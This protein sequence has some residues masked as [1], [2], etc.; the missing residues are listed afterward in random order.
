MEKAVQRTLGW[1]RRGGLGPAQL[2]SWQAD[3]HAYLCAWQVK[4]LA[5][6]SLKNPVRIFVNSNT[7]VAPFLRQEFIRIRPNREGDREAIVA[8]GRKPRAGLGRVGCSSPLASWGPHR[9]SWVSPWCL[10]RLISLSPCVLLPF[11]QLHHFHRV[12]SPFL[13]SPYLSPT[14]QSS[15]CSAELTTSPHLPL[16]PLA[17]AT[18]FAWIIAAAAWPCSF[19]PCALV[20]HSPCCRSFKTIVYT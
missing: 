17:Q 9:S 5:S 7:D 6:V 19:H 15:L 13:L 8:G 14:I 11:T 4:D 16:W 3:E 12:L 20:M 1:A 18:A 10:F 2:A